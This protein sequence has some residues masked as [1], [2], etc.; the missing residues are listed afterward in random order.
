M[1]NATEITVNGVTLT[2]FA[3]VRAGLADGIPLE[4]LLGF[5]PLDAAAWEAAEE[6]WDERILDAVGDVDAELLAQLDAK[7]AE[8][9]TRW[10]RQVPPLDHELRAW[11]AFL[12]AW[13]SDA[14]PVEY[15]RRMGLGTADVAYL[16]RLWSER[17]TRDAKLRE[18][19]LALAGDEPG[20]PPVPSP[21]PPKLVRSPRATPT[22]DNVTADIPLG[23][24]NTL[25]FA[26][27]EPAPMPPP[28]AVPLPR[29]RRPRTTAPGVDETRLGGAARPEGPLPFVAGDGRAAAA[30]AE[31][32]AV[33]VGASSPAVEVVHEPAVEPSARIPVP[34]PPEVAQVA[35]RIPEPTLILPV[36]GAMLASAASSDA[37]EA[38]D[39]D[40]TT[41]IRR[42]T[43]A[44]IPFAEAFRDAE[45]RAERPA[46]AMERHAALV[47]ELTTG[48]DPSELLARYDLTPEAKE[49]EDERWAR[50]LD[51]DPSMR[52]AWMRAF[53]AVRARLSAGGHET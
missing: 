16:H 32:V 18:E 40:R 51:R 23:K 1:A 24:G 25:P 41:A 35:P 5:L 2:Q 6:P 42:E 36:T 27:G 11:L 10:T 48:G 52:R 50:E 12:E 9:R 33:A 49:R 21:E 3:F 17:M 38:P 8:A 4:E 46:L 13:K 37:G 29:R 45:P 28:L 14:E 22:G 31:V 15:L 30:F 7:T 53:A 44:V 19:A 26:E 47:A 39:L 20:E 34:P 43:G